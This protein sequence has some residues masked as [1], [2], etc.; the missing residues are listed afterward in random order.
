MEISGKVPPLAK[1]VYARPSTKPVG[2]TEPVAA[3]KGDRVDLSP[4]AREVQAAREA[5]AKMD[6]VDH[7]KVA[8][9][10]AQIAAGT[11]KVDAAKIASKIIAGSLL[12]DIE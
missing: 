10:K 5:L 9:I 11:Y 2:K 1:T 6:A 7:E 8:R 12:D 3:T 4:Q